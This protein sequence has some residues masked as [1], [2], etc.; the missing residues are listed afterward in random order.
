M[1]IRTDEVCTECRRHRNGA[2]CG[3]CVSTELAGLRGPGATF[4]AGTHILA[5]FC[6][7]VPRSLAECAARFLEHA[8]PDRSLLI[9][10]SADCFAFLFDVQFNK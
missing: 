3:N 7:Y 8:E 4:P 6:R 5:V 2:L 9:G 10:R 1:F